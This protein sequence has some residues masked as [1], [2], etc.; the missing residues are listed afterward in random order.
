M[1]FK[2]RE[3]AEIAKKFKNVGPTLF[4]GCC[5]IRPSHI[6]MFSKLK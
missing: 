2:D 6:E 5:E 4:D 3:M 1:N